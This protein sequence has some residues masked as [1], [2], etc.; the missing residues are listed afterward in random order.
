M[1]VQ[2]FIVSDSSTRET[3]NQSEQEIKNSTQIN[4]VPI[5]LNASNETEPA[6]PPVEPKTRSGSK[7]TSV[8]ITTV[9][10]KT[11]SQVVLNFPVDAGMILATMYTYE[12]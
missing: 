5:A 3:Y 9:R 4:I 11:P 12:E 6:P 8:V 7:G 2:S 1:L 10:D